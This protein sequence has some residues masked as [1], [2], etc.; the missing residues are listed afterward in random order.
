MHVGTS[1]AAGVICAQAGF[2]EC[3]LRS[4][5]RVANS[6][7]NAS[8]EVRRHG[9]W[10]P[11]RDALWAFLDPHLSAGARVAVL[12]AG[13]ADDLPLQRMVARARSVA[14]V[15]LDP[16]ATRAARRRLH[17]RA[18]RR[19]EVIEHDVTGGVADTIAVCAAFGEVPG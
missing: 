15:D 12:G 10:A 9:R 2:A 6:S 11:A 7:R 8:A 18:R 13:N 1:A 16:R 19:V 17:R 5:S 14:L 3:R 4:P